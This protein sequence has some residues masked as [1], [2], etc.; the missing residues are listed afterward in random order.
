MRL[1]ETASTLKTK[2]LAILERRFEMTTTTSSSG[3][4]LVAIT[5]ADMDTQGLSMD[6]LDA[7]LRSLAANYPELKI[8]WKYDQVNEDPPEEPLLNQNYQT[9]ARVEV[10]SNFKELLSTIRTDIV[11][12]IVPK[13]RGSKKY[14]I[15]V[16]DRQ[17]M[18]NDSLPLSRP[19]FNSV[20]SNAFERMYKSPGQKLLRQDF[21]DGDPLKKDFDDI[22]RDLNFREGLQKLFFPAISKSAIIFR[23]PVYESDISLSP[24]EQKKLDKYLKSLK[25]SKN[26]G[27]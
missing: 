10:P 14:W 22:V 11:D 17:I 19:D 1:M 9:F 5:G 8:I 18:L 23:N 26:S 6:D 21:K 2:V 27:K 25:P 4:Q 13:I 24:A 7:T 20:N 16:K 15:G 3:N 12:G